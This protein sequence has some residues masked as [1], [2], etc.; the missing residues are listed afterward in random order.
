MRI[1]EFGRTGRKVSEIGFG[2]WAIGAAWGEVNDEEAL[3]ALHA[4][5]DTGVTF[6]DTADV[7][8]DGHSEQLIAKVVKQRRGERPFIATKAGRRL[9]EQSVEG[10]TAENLNNWIDRS[11]KNLET[12]CLDLLQLHCPPTDLYYRPE[13]FG[14]L[15]RLVEQGK[16]RNYGV[17]VERVEEAL[18]A[19]EYPGVASIQI[20]FN[21]F[22]QRPIEHFFKQ[23]SEK[24]VA[25]IARVPLASG[26]LS[27]K[28]KKDT[29]FEANDH[30]LFNR[31]GEAFDVGET[32]SG[33]PYEIGLDAVERI[34]PLVSGDTTM[35]KFAL[36]WILMF[37]AVTVA[38]PGARNPAQ[39]SSNAEAAALPAIPGDA[40]QEIKAIYDTYIKQY[41]HQRW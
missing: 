34:R 27:G 19:I 12:D 26:L 10:Y 14:Q 40:M 32:F 13:V 6:I 37:D 15:D 38:I 18:K 28:F 23:A 17:S 8:G 5:L 35:A 16:I 3:A 21:A 4:A 20:I 7:Y 22:R 31:N 1:K 33:V 2:A 30:R 36:R 25:V 41:V 29:K 39:A 11:L 24:Q 9:P